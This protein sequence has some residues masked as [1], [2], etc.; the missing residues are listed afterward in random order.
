MSV[1]SPL[2]YGINV[3]LSQ[4]LIGELEGLGRKVRSPRC[5]LVSAGAFYIYRLH[6]SLIKGNIFLNL[7]VVVTVWT[8]YSVSCGNPLACISRVPMMLL[9][10]LT[11]WKLIPPQDKLLLVK[12]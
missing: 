7:G 8:V 11:H 1:T 2:S 9:R 6:R 12:L 10:K 5:L 4:G 3:R